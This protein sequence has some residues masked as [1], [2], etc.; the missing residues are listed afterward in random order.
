MHYLGIDVSLATLELSDSEGAFRE[1][2]ANSLS[3]HRKL[4]RQ[5]RLRLP[6]QCVR[7][8]IEPTSTYHERLIASLASAGIGHVLVS[9]LRARRYASS[10]GLRAKTDRVDARMLARM[11][12][13]EMLAESR[14]PEEGKQR[15]RALRRH[16]QWLEDEAI[17]VRNRLG[18]ANASPY[19]PSSVLRT[20]RRLV[21]D[22]ERQAE[23]TEREIERTVKEDQ[24]L[25]TRAQLLTSVPGIGVK[26]ALLMLT[27]LPSPEECADSRSWPAFCG[28]TPKTVQ[29]G[30]VSYAVLSRA[31]RPDLR[32]HLY[33]PA[34]V[35]MR[36]NPAV[37]AYAARLAARGKT[38]KKAIMA[39]MH[40]L[41]RI[42]FGV[43]KTGRP[44]DPT[45]HLKN[46]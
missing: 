32:A 43:L 9:P 40:K 31:G 20:L 5:A 25:S 6:Q 17:S 28:A 27:E 45:L 23:E 29:S 1:T 11:G 26:S 12:E 39:A 30:K 44:F 15:L 3:G 8:V 35:A 2:Y 14:P 22:L 10:L 36:A 41:L 33:M 16:L 24:E 7:M 38:G 42:C 19:T 4:I 34:M 21:K 18:A 13:R 37:A 46:A